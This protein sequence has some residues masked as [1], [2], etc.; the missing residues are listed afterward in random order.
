MKLFL[1][2]SFACSTFL[3]HAQHDYPN[4]KYTYFKMGTTSTSQCYDKN[5][6]FGKARAYNLKGDKIYE[7][8]LRAVGGHSSVQFSFFK[9]GSVRKAEWRSAPDGG[10]QWYSNVTTFSEDGTQLSSINNNY[11]DHV[12]TIQPAQKPAE[13]SPVIKD[14][15]KLKSETMTCAVI[16]SNEF[17]YIIHSSQKIIITAVRN[18][19]DFFTDCQSHSC[20][21]IFLF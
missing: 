4:C 19:D 6:R 9:N 10:I 11:D 15:I 20:P 2:L 5:N 8:E 1:F 3:V 13:E 12:T 16:Y 7:R 14:S 21:V 18:K 17:W